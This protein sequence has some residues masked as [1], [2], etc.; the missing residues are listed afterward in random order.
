MEDFSRAVVVISIEEQEKRIGQLLTSRGLRLLDLGNDAR[1]SCELDQD[2]VGNSKAKY[3]AHYET[4]DLSQL[5]EAVE[6][7][8][9]S[10]RYKS[11]A[12]GA[13]QPKE[14]SGFTRFRI[15]LLLY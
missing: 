4:P 8:I 15:A 6:K 7:E 1:K 11:A 12:V 5:P 14:A 3:V 9:Q 2:Y 10:H 13:C